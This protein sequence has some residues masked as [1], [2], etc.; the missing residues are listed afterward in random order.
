LI[1]EDLNLLLRQIV[2]QLVQSGFKLTAIGKVLLGSNSYTPILKLA[3]EDT[4][5]F[6]YKPLARIGRL[7]HKNLYLVYL[8]DSE[9]DSNLR[10][11]IEQKNSESLFLLK[12]KIS[13]FLNN[14]ENISLD[15]EEL[16]SNDKL[17][18]ILN[19]ILGENGETKLE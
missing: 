13:N 4:T 19:N 9:E 6:G 17:N 1:L 18:Q 3:D 12:E 2:L 15:N 11:I 5:L 10:Q 8:D 16:I 7:L 14:K